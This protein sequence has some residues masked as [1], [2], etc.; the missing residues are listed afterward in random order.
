MGG[1]G[2]ISKMSCFWSF[3]LNIYLILGEDLPV[4]HGECIAI[5]LSKIVTDPVAV[6]T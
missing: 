4:F 2:C 6:D 5:R 1:G 3:F